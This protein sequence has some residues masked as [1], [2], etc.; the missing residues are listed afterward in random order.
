MCSRQYPHVQLPSAVSAVSWLIHSESACV[1]PGSTQ[2]RLN[3]SSPCTGRVEVLYNGHWGRVCSHSWDLPDAEVVCKQLECGAAVS[4]PHYKRPGRLPEDRVLNS[5]GCL[6]NETQLRECKSGPWGRKDCQHEWDAAVICAGTK[7]IRLGIPYNCASRVDL[8]YRGQWGAVCWNDFGINEAHVA[9]RQAGCGEAETYSR[10]YVHID[11]APIWLDRVHCTGNETNLWD[12]PSDTWGHHECDLRMQAAVVCK[13]LANESICVTGAANLS[14]ADGGSPCAGRL[15]FATSIVK[16]SFYDDAIDA[17]VAQV[18]CSQLDC[19]SAVSVKTGAYFGETPGS[20]WTFPV[21]CNGNESSF[22]Q[23]KSD[24]LFSVDVVDYPQK[25]KFLGVVCSGH[26]APRLVDGEDSC[27]GRVEV[28]FGETWGTL[29]DTHWDMHDA[30][31]VCKQLQCGVAVAT[32]GGAHFGEGKG[33]MWEEQFDCWGNESILFD[34]PVSRKDHSCTH[35]SHA[36][37]ICSEGQVR[38]VGADSPCSGRVELCHS[39]S[40]GTVCD[41]SWDLNDAHVVCTQLLCGSAVTATQEARFGEGNGMIWLDDV[42]CRGTEMFLLGCR[43]STP[44]LHNCEHNEDAGV[45][46]SGTERHF[47][48]FDSS[49]KMW[50]KHVF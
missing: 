48:H 2:L 10:F 42:N 33:P 9:C 13:A 18:L 28:Q 35:G 39:G 43:S 26:R 25:S 11:D 16:S 19:G 5:V 30:S 12:C 3:G 14:L 34:C 17:S 47:S 7:K 46:C 37:V 36:A 21:Y 50:Q 45:I 38:L 1:S 24:I 22:W 20:F 32:P 29:C 4:A 41:D 27:S 6:G 40:W 31:V 23:C 15:E 8:Y 44:G 49:P